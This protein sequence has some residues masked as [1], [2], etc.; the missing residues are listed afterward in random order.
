MHPAFCCAFICCWTF[1]LFLPSGCYPYA[2]TVFVGS[3]FASLLCTDLGVEWLGHMI[4]LY[5]TFLRNHQMAFHLCYLLMQP[6]PSVLP[7]CVQSQLTARLKSSQARACLA[8]CVLRLIPVTSYWPDSVASSWRDSTARRVGPS[9]AHSQLSW[10]LA[11]PLRCQELQ[12]WG[13]LSSPGRSRAGIRAAL[14]K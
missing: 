8:L 9:R 11:P 14:E 12:P 3:P 2:D 7:G 6:E 5:F 10:G 1:E 13:L 4:I